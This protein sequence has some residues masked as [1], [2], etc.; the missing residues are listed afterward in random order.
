MYVTF[1]KKPSFTGYSKFSELNVNAGLYLLALPEKI[2]MAITE[3]T[4]VLS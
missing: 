1:Q 2:V 3:E 4:F